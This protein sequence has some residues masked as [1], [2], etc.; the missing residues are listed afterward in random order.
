MTMKGHSVLL[1][2]IQFQIR[3]HFVYYMVEVVCCF[4]IKCLEINVVN[5]SLVRAY[6]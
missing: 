5:I 2:V 1:L 3:V 4:F 6:H